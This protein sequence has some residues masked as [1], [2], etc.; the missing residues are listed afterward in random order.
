MSMRRIIV[1]IVLAWVIGVAASLLLLNRNMVPKMDTV[2]LNKMVKLVE[3][4]WA[5]VEQGDYSEVKQEF[6]VLDAKGQLVYTTSSNIPLSVNEAIQQRE[7]ALDVTINDAIVGKVLV[8]HDYNAVLKQLQQRLMLVLIL[9]FTLIALLCVVYVWLLNRNVFTPFRKLQ[10]FAY[11]IAS[12]N[13]D[14][15]LEMDRSNLFGA[16]SESF[17]MMREQLAESRQREYEANRSK[18]ELVASLS[19]DI[20][21]PVASIKAVSELMIVTATDE[22]QRKQLSTIASK[23]DQIDLLITDMFHA[24]LEEL[25]E[26]KVTLSE[27]YSSTISAMID[28]NNYDNRIKCEAIPPCIILIDPIRLQQVLDNIMSNSYKYANSEIRISFALTEQ[29]LEM[30]IMDYGKGVTEEELTLLFNKYYRGKQAAGQTGSGL[31]LYISNYLMGKMQ[32]YIAC[33][34]REDGF[35]VK[36]SVKLA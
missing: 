19:H 5:D 18:K 12:G 27:Q 36:V 9:S 17:D 20:K 16:F 1:F 22:K 32:G 7:L 3:H 23:V 29:D 34:N 6:A 28:N 11:H 13:L 35:T 30:S 10:K 31:G 33:S 4:H 14:I 26:L 24:T 15:P 21:T 8:F 25:D 2:A